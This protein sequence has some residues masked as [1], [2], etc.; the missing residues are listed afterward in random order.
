P[1]A[2]LLY[3][4]P[5]EVLRPVVVRRTCRAVLDFEV[6]NLRHHVI[7]NRRWRNGFLIELD[8]LAELFLDAPNPHVLPRQ[9]QPNRDIFTP[10]T[11]RID[12]RR[13]GPGQRRKSTG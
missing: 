6:H 8:I 2:V 1:P 4:S 3:G 11:S 13:V 12:G 10:E 9:A 7:W 5:Q